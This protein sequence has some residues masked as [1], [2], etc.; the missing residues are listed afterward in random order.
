[1]PGASDDAASS[2]DERRLRE[3][4]AR[5]ERLIDWEKKARGS[6]R[7]SIEPARDLCGRLGAPEQAFACVHVAGSKGKGSTCAL[8]AAGL[9]QAGFKVGRYGSPHVERLNERVAIDGREIE[10]G[11]LAA[12]LER[13]FE[14]HQAACS[15]RSAAAQATWFDL[16]T[17][18]AFSALAQAG[19]QWGV[20]EVGLGGR[21]DSTNVVRP[22]VCVITNIELE[23]TQVLGSTVAAIASEKAG[24]LKLGAALVTGVPL[25]SEAGAVIEARSRSLGVL[26]RRPDPARFERLDIEQR[27]VWLAGAALDELGSS[28]VVGPTGA[29]VSSALLSQPAFEGARLPG[30]LERFSVAG[31]P[32]ILDGAHTPSSVALVVEQLGREFASRGKPQVVIGLAHDKDLAG[33]LKGL[34][35]RVDRLICTSVGSQ[36]HRAP[37]QIA[38][39]AGQAGMAVETSATPMGALQA[40]LERARRQGGWVLVVGSLYLAGSLRPLLR[41]LEQ[42]RSC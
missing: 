30:R 28:G 27:N 24:I 31:L 8:I 11:D 36:L 5:Y 16:V 17:A 3:I 21:L 34:A 39:E 38:S 42:G 4:V 37:E 33:M 9:G 7:V 22:A 19:V 23:H 6:M 12:A 32:V 26:T 2:R 1:M 15:A 10:D 41:R 18:A 25:A 13:A 40:A 29:P 14:A 20:I 35:G